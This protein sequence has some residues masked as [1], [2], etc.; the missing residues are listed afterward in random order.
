MKTTMIHK[1]S[2]LG[3]ML[4]IFSGF[5][6]SQV[7]SSLD[8]NSPGTLRTEILNAAP[9]ATLTITTVTPI[10]LTNGQIT[11]DKNLTLV[12]VGGS[13]EIDGNSLGRIFDI[14]APATSVGISNC[15]FSNGIAANGGAIQVVGADLLLVSTTFTGNTANGAS[16]S[17]GAIFVGTGATLDASL[18]TFNNN[19]ANRAGGAIEIV[20]GTTLNLTSVDLISNNAGV[21]PAV[22]APGNGGGLHVTGT[23]T[24][25]ITGGNVANNV[26]A[27]EGGGLWN[28]SGMMTIDGTNI[29]NNTASGDGPDNGGGGIY[30]LNNG[31]LTISNATI[32]ANT[33][34]GTAGSGGGILND[35]GA[36]LTITNTTIAANVAN[37]AG[38]GI[39]GNATMG[40]NM[41]SLTDVQMNGNNAGV[42]PAIASPG[43]GGGLHMTGPGTI[44]ITNGTVNGN[45]A[46]SEG[47]GLWNGTGTMTID[48][49][50]ILGNTASG[51][52]ADNG[53]GGIYNLNNGTL[54]ISNAT[55]S[56][57]SA[58]GLAGSGGGILNDIGATA[59]IDAT[60][61]TGNSSMRAGGAIEVNAT[62]SNSFLN[63]TD[64]DFDQ[65]DA[66]MSPGNGG[67]L[68][69][70]GPGTIS[71]IDGSVTN[72]TA[73]TEGGGLWNGSGTMNITGTLLSGNTA[74][75][76]N[77]DNGGGAIYNFNGGT[78]NISNATIVDNSANGA[79]GSGG[80]ILNDV[81]AQLSVSN[82]TISTN[83]ANRAG[84]GIEDNS[85]SSTII[86]DTVMLNDN[87]TLN[88]PGNGGG[89]HITGA[90]SAIITAGTV[91]DNS[92][93]QEGGGLWNGSGVMTIVGTVIDGNVALGVAAHDGGAGIFN[94]SGTVTITDALIA[95]NLATG[96]SGS[97]GG[98]LSLAGTVA[99]ENSTFAQN[100][101]TRAGGAIEVIDG[102]L[103]IMSSIFTANDV[104]GTAGAANPGNGGAIHISDTAT[105][106]ID[107]SEFTA[108]LAG[109]E[110]GAVWNQT[111][112]TMTITNSTIDGNIANGAGATNGGGGVFVNGGTVIISNSTISNNVSTGVDANGGGIHVKVGTAEL[113][114]STISG[115]TSAANGGGI[116]TNDGLSLN[117][118]TIAN[119]SAVAEGGGVANMGMVASTMKNSLI[120][121]NIG[122]SADVYA[123]STPTLSNGY[124][125]IGSA[126]ASAITA[127]ATDLIGS[128]TAVLDP[129]IGALAD[130]GG[131]TETHALLDG[132]IAYNAGDVVDM[133]NDQIGQVVFDG[134][135]D[136]GAFEAQ[137]DL[138][139]LEELAT[140][141]VSIFPNP[142]VDGQ[143]TIEFAHSEIEGRDG[144]IIEV[145]SGR[146]VQK[147]E[148][149]NQT[150]K[151]TLKNNAP[152]MYL[153]Q[154]N[155]SSGSVVYKVQV[156]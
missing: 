107:Q 24:V 49:T 51:D 119:N 129:M 142:V 16:G 39:E 138:L 48:G 118:V 28:G 17:G 96:T 58:D 116:Y 41:I 71:I 79:S 149:N 136:I 152:G 133:F 122:A 36:T 103:N 5:S 93:G 47:G 84:G 75:G 22:A 97:G 145:G 154:L 38:G 74:S 156:H 106:M 33:A 124:N 130:N 14:V 54:F 27:S 18:S 30:N 60:T 95:N 65:N 100:S 8:D 125:L 104:N 73:A 123:A 25:T 35:V 57:N 77:A 6:Y 7:T 143:L 56:G 153:V 114:T 117:A 151:V 115:N 121:T 134:R 37:R 112:S 32:A 146:L 81:G 155:T 19:T 2:S 21:M 132:S 91:N 127:V 12:G 148:L 10:V 72:N 59:T 109:R 46:A 55:I 1:A 4:L 45:T 92:A 64:V 83:S 13:V 87:V 139:S 3:A 120:A 40:T 31:N 11:I 44:T 102:T 29:V 140:L 26:A 150:T 105:I 89:L 128:S 68:H 137:Y 52:A 101:A 53:G 141:G 85:G 43:N 111:G 110:G 15:T 98:I 61:F 63:L 62:G 126:D 144:S 50:D 147:F 90:G 88:A 78:L 67:A 9:G 94:T 70:T 20:A 34:N 113:M 66:G 69:V 131:T 23:A 80:G 99:I 108:N 76:D 135:R 82:S 42:A 86:L